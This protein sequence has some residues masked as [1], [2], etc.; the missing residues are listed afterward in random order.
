MSDGKFTLKKIT[1]FTTLESCPETTLV[2][3]DLCIQDEKNIYQFKYEESENDGMI[4]I[5]PG[6]HV[7][8]QANGKI[9]IED[10]QMSTRNLLMSITNTKLIVDEANIFFNNLHVYDELNEPKARKILLYS[11]PGCGKSATIA[12]YCSDAMK[13]DPGTVIL[14]WPTSSIDSDNVLKFLTTGCVYAPTCT[15]MVFI[16]EDIGG[17]EREGS[18]NSRQVDS[19]LLDM[20]D[21]VQCTFKIPTLVIA[22]TNFPENLLNALADRPGRFDLLMQLKPPSFDERVALVEH[23]GK[24]LLSQEDKDALKSKDVDGFSIAHLKEVVIRGRLHQKPIN[25]I[26]KE[27]I[28]HRKIFKKDFSEKSEESFGFSSR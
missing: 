15:K 5:V 13:D 20:L 21:G 23:I 18:F 27:V 17:G 8:A 7:L 22:T 9:L 11:D 26:V 3:S 4:E 16:V 14:M 6:C 2:Q 25:V 1:A 12:K 24:I 10:M 28:N 19:A